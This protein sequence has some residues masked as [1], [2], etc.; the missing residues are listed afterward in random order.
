MALFNFP[1]ERGRVQRSA[2]STGKDYVDDEDDDWAD[3]DDDDGADDDS[4]RREWKSEAEAARLFSHS[5]YHFF[6]FVNSV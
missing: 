6:F 2:C 4:G 3:G 1:I 5:F